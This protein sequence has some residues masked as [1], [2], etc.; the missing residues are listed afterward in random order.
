VA[1]SQGILTLPVVVLGM[2]VVGETGSGE[3]SG[4]GKGESVG[5]A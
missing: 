4:K 3:I 5:R 1:K 2:A